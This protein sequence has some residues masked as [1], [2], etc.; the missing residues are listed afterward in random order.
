[1]VTP[2][3]EITFVVPGQAL[4]SGQ[5]SLALHGSVKAAVRVGARRG[6]GETVRITARLGDD[7]VVLHIANGPT[8]YLHPEDA[9][10]LMRA[11]AEAMPTPARGGGARPAVDGEVMVP[12]QLGWR[13]L[14]AA[15]ASR[16]GVGD[17]LGTVW[18]D[19]IE[20][21]TGLFKDTAVDL[22]T[23]AVT[24]KLDAQVDP[25]VYKLLPDELPRLKDSGNKLSKVLAASDGG[26]LLIMVHGTFVHTASTF[27]KLWSLHSARV[28]SLFQHYGGRIYA[29]DHPT[30]G[31]SPFANALTL[32]ETLP[33]GARLH[34]VTHS[35]GGIIAEV[36]ARLCGGQGLRPEDLALFHGNDYKQHRAD[37]EALGKLVKAQQLRVER[38]VRVACPARGTLLASR[39]LD[40]Y[41]SV[42]KWG[43]DLAGVPVLPELVDFLSEV[44]RRRADPAALPGLEAMMPGRP[45]AHWLNA[46]AEPVPG[47][48]RVV[49]GDIEGDAILSWL[50]TL[51]S[52]AFYW[53]DNDLVV[54][55]RSMYG[56]TPRAGGAAS[57]M[58]DRGGKV[59]HFN[60]FTNE[61]TA[62]AITNGLLQDQPDEFRAIGPL[63]WAGEEA[64]GTR[65]ARAAMR[66][67]VGNANERPAVF[68]L[69]GILG[70]HLKVDDQRVWL[71]LR[72]V[73][74]L[75]KLKWEAQTTSRVQPD[76]VVGMSYD[77]LI[78][79]LADTHEVMPFS[80]DW[81]RPIEDEARRL[82]DAIDAALAARSTTQQ[83][84]RIV[85]H[86]MGGVVMRTM[87]LERPQTWKNMMARQGARVLMLGTPNEGSWAPMQMLSGDD[88][89]GNM[90]TFLGSLF[91]DHKARQTIAEMP[92][93][94]Q[95]Q[96]A[97]LDPALGLDKSAGWQRLADADLQSVRQ[98]LDERTWWHKDELQL[99][100]YKWGIPSQTVLDQAVDLRKR[101]NAQR[102]DLGTDA[103]KMLIVVGKARF[104]PAGIRVTDA[105][106]EYLEALQDGDG[107][108]TLDSARLPGVRTWIVDVAHG[109][110]ADAKDAFEGYVELLTRG[111]TS[112]LQ[113]VPEAAL[114]VRGAS[115]GTGVSV[116]LVPSRRSRAGGG[117]EPPSVQRDVFAPGAAPE[118]PTARPV[119]PRL[120][121]SVMHGNLKFVRQPLMLGH[122]RALALTGSGSEAVMDRLLGQAMSESLRAGLY[123]SA[124]GSH[125]VFINTSRNPDNPLA[126]PR[127]AAVIVVGLGEEGTLRATD[128][129]LTVR[130]ATLAYAQRISEGSAGGSTHFE[131][132]AT[133]IGSGGSGMH[134]GTAAQAIAQGVQQA[135]ERLVAVGWPLVMQLQ[136]I[137]L[138]L[139]RATE[140]YHALK[141]LA[142]T[143]PQSFALEP[144]IRPGSGGLRRPPESGYRGAGYDFI[145]VE[146]RGDTDSAVLEFTLDTQRARS[147]V[148]GQATQVKLVDELVRAGANDRNRNQQ[149]GRSLFQLL[150]PI[151]V[152]PFLSGSAA[153]LLQL[154]RATAAYPWELLD[155]RRDEANPHDDARPWAVRTRVLRKLRTEDFRE[156]P[157]D[158]RRD[159]DTLVIGAPQCDLQIYPPLPG[160]VEEAQAVAAVLETEAR[161][162]QDAL[163]FV[164]AVLERP[165]KII[166]IAGHGDFLKDCTGGVVLSNG[167]VF[168]AREVKTMR[169][170]PELAFINCCYLGRIDPGAAMPA[171]PLG[172]KRPLFAANVAEELIKIGVR[173]VVAAGWAV[174]D[175]PAQL[176]ATCFYRELKSGHR[177]VEAVGRAREETWR[178]HQ[179]SNT[180]AAYQCY[181]DPDWR[182]E[183]SR[184]AADG[185]VPEVPLVVSPAGLD[186]ELQRL[187][188]EYRYGD[189]GRDHAQARIEQLE[190]AYGGLWG[191]RGAIAEAF[192]VGYGEL[193][194]LDNAIRWYSRAVSAEDGGASL[195]ASEQLGNLRARR[196][197]T[198]QDAAQ[199]RDEIRAAIQQLERVVAIAPT[200]EREGLLGSAFKRLAML[201]GQSRQ[202]AARSAMAQM[203]AHYHQAEELALKNNADNLYYPAMN[204]M[205]AELILNFSQ[206]NWPGF[207]AADV[208]A[209]RQSL[210]KKVMEDADFWSV[211]GLTE[212]HI[213]EA[214]A[215]R[216]LAKA[217]GDI[218][219][220][221]QDLKARVS[222]P[223]LWDSVFAQARFTLQPYIG[224]SRIPA[225][226]HEAANKLL[227]Q[228]QNNA[229][230]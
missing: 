40:V 143:Y 48:L 212:L 204:R 147:E 131:L 8:L 114:G 17:W 193:G 61:R 47:D 161:L 183:S 39:R 123:P 201:E 96:A 207:A 155:T 70:S 200:S 82:A 153:V 4:P 75:D 91:D 105:G 188:V 164:N 169:I 103:M 181:G 11:Q 43:L 68:V 41:L 209:V 21:V 66:S 208:A 111:D 92:G 145:T 214:L 2:A 228:L 53:T 42:L 144:Q 215:Q 171:S 170:V 121:V 25:G 199:G 152:E 18:V 196:G 104:T 223:H 115:L 76:G 162:N 3:Q 186:L 130:Q 138:Y 216:Q 139:D 132:S 94:L 179:Q 116:S 189:I 31:A 99:E 146:R 52:D 7:V 218:L 163:A 142:E 136:L 177:F 205:S 67:R 102:Q 113:A 187:T 57:F 77:D 9:R 125:Q 13:G 50:K 106:I 63:S 160:A 78:D 149:I 190:A 80:F 126:V 89:F 83:P 35:R 135:N 117:A 176:F 100:P 198:M 213:Y 60:Y 173:C 85:A 120:Q 211:V 71:S 55:T 226:E 86:S 30:V 10:E 192:G 73:N 79:Y 110:L 46:P 26:P 134:V 37:L 194:E 56:G 118:A 14:D 148:R 62:N 129:T 72:F 84:V 90:L 5:A 133:V 178:A 137:E 122:Y 109:S 150:V 221:L 154:D 184:G 64:S 222:A 112:K 19:A 23:A 128:L 95:L 217:L 65:A 197:E 98:R 141:A 127:P 87:Q 185:Q 1:M 34:F 210:Q 101:L 124:V 27:G 140:T 32:A 15:A 159:A 16:G 229:V 175:T 12:A 33:Q 230:L 81:R 74:S 22:V 156:Q 182:Y 206:P 180:W 49:A 225:A 36:L 172:D 58:L 28:R 69:P 202:R 93:L 227:A 29:L 107:R 44:A 168:G 51:L 151:E 157:L 158:V 220:E 119:G 24:K 224:A 167:T 165:Y 6:G 45:V 88:T 20:V 219:A 174:D 59:T 54:Q 195:R 203:A 38:V 191:T 97:L 166:H 108:V